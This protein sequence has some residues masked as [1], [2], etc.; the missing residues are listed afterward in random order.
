MK[1]KIICT[2][3]GADFELKCNDE[4]HDPAYCP[5]CGADLF[6]EEDDDE[7]ERYEWS[8]PDNDDYS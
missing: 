3:C 8:D 2:D 1:H 7:E 4:E 5:F 6:W